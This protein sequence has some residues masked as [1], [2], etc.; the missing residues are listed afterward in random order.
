MNTG[1]YG[2]FTI[3]SYRRNPDYAF[4]ISDN[5]ASMPHVNRSDTPIG[6]IVGAIIGVLLLLILGVA[7]A[8][9]VLYLVIET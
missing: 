8:V 3:E 5:I 1:V 7:I 6:A 2:W 4:L 9:V